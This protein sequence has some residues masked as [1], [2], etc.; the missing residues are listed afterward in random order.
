MSN[1]RVSDMSDDEIRDMAGAAPSPAA[2][3][4]AARDRNEHW[5]T[6]MRLTE[7]SVADSPFGDLRKAL[8]AVEAVLALHQPG[9]TVVLG[10]VCH[11]HEA[12]RHFSI[13]AAEADRCRACPA[14]EATVSVACT[15]GYVDAERCP[16]RQA[17][18][19]GLLG[20]EDGHD[21]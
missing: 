3:I 20:K 1:K 12:F 14:C 19:A 5:I 6:S 10:A 2:W 11:D 13:T 17:I 16:H 9:W 15:C 8:A 21:S 18:A 7:A 4:A